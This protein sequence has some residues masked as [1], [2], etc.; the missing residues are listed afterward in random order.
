MP[1]D[2]Q[3]LEPVSGLGGPTVLFLGNFFSVSHP[4]VVMQSS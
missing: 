2:P 4:V 1:L 3:V